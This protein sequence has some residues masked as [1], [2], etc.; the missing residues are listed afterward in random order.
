[1]IYEYSFK[2]NSS[3]YLSVIYLRRVN[4]GSCF[5]NHQFSE[6]SKVRHIPVSAMPKKS[7][8]PVLKKITLETMLCNVLKVNLLW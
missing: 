5:M 2:K 3:V 1:M 8:V 4:R 6:F 7:S